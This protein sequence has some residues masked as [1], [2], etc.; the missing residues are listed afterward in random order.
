[1]TSGT[2]VLVGTAV[3]ICVV[4][5]VT[6]VIYRVMGSPLGLFKLNK[7]QPFHRGVLMK[8][9]VVDRVLEPGAH[10]IWSR[11]TVFLCDARPIPFQLNSQ[12][13][14]CRQT[15]GFE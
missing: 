15:R 8:G 4:A 11:R 14:R 3:E 12:D 10:W 13:V 6:G 9:E 2:D 7:I 5:I 1:M